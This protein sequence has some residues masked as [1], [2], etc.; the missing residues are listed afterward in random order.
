MAEDTIERTHYYHADAS[1]IGGFI[2]R[3]FTGTVPSHASSSLPLVGGVLE[4]EH[5]GRKWKNT[6]SYASASTTVSGKQQ[7]TTS[8][9]LALEAPG[10][11]ITE[12]TAAVND[13][14][15]RE[16]ITAK[17]VV[18]QL[19]VVHPQDGYTP[20]I[21]LTGSQIVDLRISGIPITPIINYDLFEG[22]D[23]A[24]N[25]YPSKPWPEQESLQKHAER[26]YRQAGGGT[27]ETP[28]WVRHH[29]HW[30]ETGKSG[31]TY[32][33]PP[34]SIVEGFEGVPKNFPGKVFAH[35]IYVRDFGRIFFGELLV[36][37][38]TYSLSMIRVKLGSPVGGA[39]SAAT[40]QSNGKTF[41]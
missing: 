8:S 12:V 22:F 29:F 21:Y 1:A 5:R 30:I 20:K 2:T 19:S 36:E 15:I 6:V 37:A 16:V 26:Q 13:L 39:I 31:N 35:S 34:C 14:N 23:A 10:P 11:W 3:P 41:P 7:T 24:P 25:G 9:G 17:R 33:A 4:K 38:G 27:E 28:A 40:A 32:C 18:A